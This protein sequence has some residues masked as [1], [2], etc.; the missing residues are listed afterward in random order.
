MSSKEKKS[1]P[2]YYFHRFKFK[3]GMDIIASLK[4]GTRYILQQKDN[5]ITKHTSFEF[6]DIEKNLTEKTYFICRDT[7]Q[8]MQSGLITDFIL[9]SKRTTLIKLVNNYLSGNGTHWKSEVYTQLYP[10]WNKI[11]FNFV[12]LK[13]LSTLF[14]GYKIDLDSFNH[15]KLI[16]LQNL[17]EIKK[18]IPENLSEPLYDIA[19]KDNVWL[20]RMMRGEHN[21]IVASNYE[22]WLTINRDTKKFL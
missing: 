14:N 10:I 3:N 2:S 8:H 11:G 12:E 22:E 9:N 21:V 5:K 13:D 6:C 17:D 7:I 1:N 19:K 4:C 18:S 20:G 15:R 16:G